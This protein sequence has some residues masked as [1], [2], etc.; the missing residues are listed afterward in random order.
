[1]LCDAAKSHCPG[2]GGIATDSTKK[3]HG[4][5]CCAPTLDSRRG[6]GATSD[7]CI[8]SLPANTRIPRTQLQNRVLRKSCSIKTLG[9]W[10]SKQVCLFEGSRVCVLIHQRHWLPDRLPY[11]NR[12]AITRR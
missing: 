11:S 3:V 10:F 1:M 2:A 7:G 6:A 4:G 5:T 12:M 8:T 9:E